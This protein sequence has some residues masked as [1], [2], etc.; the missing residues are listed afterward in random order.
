MEDG[1]FLAYMIA[2]GFMAAAWLIYVFGTRFYR[3]D[4]FHT[5]SEPLLTI[6]RD[7]LLSGRSHTMWKVDLTGWSLIP[8][9]I[10]IS[11]VQALV[12][13]FALT[14][15]SLVLDVVCIACLCLAHRDNSWLGKPDA[16]TRGLDVVPALLVGNTAFNVLYN[17]MSNVFY[18]QACQSD[19]RLGSGKDAFKLSGAFFNL[20]DSA[21]IIVFTPL[22]DRLL[23][24]GAERLLG[25]SSARSWGGA[26]GGAWR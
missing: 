4:S 21:A 2:A 26:P 3:E 22:I 8:V 9:L 12:P 5:Y 10:A 18:S 25:R 16:V 15:A 20:A 19:L 7:R 6:C 14:L 11:I 24:P 1:Y 13:S 23:I 17:T